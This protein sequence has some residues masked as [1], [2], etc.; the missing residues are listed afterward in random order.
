M[1]RNDSCILHV[2]GSAGLRAA[3]RTI[4]NL[5]HSDKEHGHVL[6]FEFN[7]QDHR[8]NSVEAMLSTFVAQIVSRY[9]D[10]VGPSVDGFFKSRLA[11]K[12]W[13]PID[14]YTVWVN[15]NM[16]AIS[17]L[18]T[19][20]V[21]SGLDQCKD[22]TSW[23]LPWLAQ[24]FT[25][26][27]GR[28][29]L[30]ITSA[31]VTNIQQKLK[32]VPTINLD[33]FTTSTGD[34][35]NWLGLDKASF[36]AKALQ[37]LSPT[38]EQQAMLDRI[39]S[40][41]W[42]D[43]DLYRMIL[44]WLANVDGF[45]ESPIDLDAKLQALTEL[46][47]LTPQTIAST[48]MEFVPIEARKIGRRAI[49][50]LL[51]SFQPLTKKELASVLALAPSNE[52]H[53][54]VEDQLT[55]IFPYLAGFFVITEDCV[56]FAHPNI[57]QVVLDTTPEAQ[58]L[59]YTFQGQDEVHAE[60]AQ[61]C[62]SYLRRID[63][64]KEMATS[65]DRRNEKFPFLDNN[66]D[67][68][69]Y[70]ACHWAKHYKLA[71]PTSSLWDQCLQFVNTNAGATFQCWAKFH[72]LLSNPATRPEVLLT[73][74]LAIASAL[75]LN[76]LVS[77][78]FQVHEAD[79]PLASIEA[80]RN[81]HADILNNHLSRMEP[82]NLAMSDIIRASLSSGN[83]DSLK[84]TVNYVLKQKL[85]LSWPSYLLHLVCMF[86]LN[87][88]AEKLLQS[89]V[90]VNELVFEKHSALHFASYAG[91]AQVVETLI[92]GGARVNAADA[93]YTPLHTACLWGHV[94]VAQALMRSGADLKLFT[95]DNYT[96]L[97]RSC[98]FG[99]YG[100]I[101]ILCKAE[102]LAITGSG[103]NDNQPILKC[104]SK[105]FLES[106]RTLLK[107]GADV[108]SHGPYRKTPLYCAVEGGHYNV[109][110][111]LLEKGANADQIPK[112]GG[113][114]VVSAAGSDHVEIVDLLLN[115]GRSDRS[116]LDKDRYIS[117]AATSLYGAVKR[118][119]LAMVDC[120]LRWGADI[121]MKMDD[122]KT[123]VYVAAENKNVDVLQRLVDAGADVDLVTTENFAALQIAH[124]SAE[125][126]RILLSAKKKPDINR[127]SPRGSILYRASKQNCV[128]VVEIL[129]QH[130]P[131]LETP[132]PYSDFYASRSPLLA[133]VYQ[134]HPEIVQMLLQA[135]ANINQ[136]TS[137]GDRPLHYAIWTKLQASNEECL[138]IL[139]E[140]HPDIDALD[141][142]LD[143]PLHCVTDET[144]VLSIRR[145]INAGADP[146]ISNRRGYT[147]V[148]MAII[149][150]NFP[151]VNYLVSKRRVKMDLP[152][153]EEGG[154]LHLACKIASLDCVKLLVEHHADV[155]LVNSGMAGTPLQSA[156]QRDPGEEQTQIIEYLINDPISKVD[157]NKDG[158]L[159]G[160][161]LNVASLMS[162]P[163]I[164][165]M[166]IDNHAEIDVEDYMSRNP[167][168]LAS[169][170]TLDHIDFFLD[171]PQLFS[172]QD[173]LGRTAIHFAVGSGRADLVK[174]VLT[175]C[176]RA[177]NTKDYDSWT[178]LMWAA[179]GCKNR[180]NYKDTKAD[181]QEEII[182][183]LLAQDADIWATAR[184]SGKDWSP[185][186]LAR[187]HGASD[188]II[189]LL[190]AKP[191]SISECPN[192]CN[193][194]SQ[195]CPVHEDATTT[196]SDGSPPFGD[197][198]LMS[199]WD[200]RLH[201]SKKA[202][203]REKK[204]CMACTFV[205]IENDSRRSSSNSASGIV[206]SLLPMFEML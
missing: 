166:L 174:K 42:P 58:D 17:S 79:L 156:C 170:R 158:G 149:K 184:N 49:A 44:G 55:P 92:K 177:P 123:P 141:V 112:Y 102:P 116:D 140:Y 15:P 147:P 126:V 60:I 14:L 76:D 70:V 28:L 96:P 143:T 168:H 130:N 183:F 133:A 175:L 24:T 81:G 178:P 111:L 34:N 98:V 75:G 114:V 80:A 136:S 13:N 162:T 66:Y 25:K 21:I 62:L 200:E 120:L 155:D 119:S 39:L 161:A 6:F 36:Q 134:G 198:K 10:T 181:Q 154:P 129:L 30:V 77:Y 118:G 85:S 190:S 73:S 100:V 56:Q 185:L 137:N 93:G 11:N 72:Y 9:W 124:D 3:S 146:E 64:Q 31:K 197:P 107:A 67:L 71:K 41:S 59:W 40:E 131:D 110:K 186:K 32:E 179:R 176:G 188:S 65:W 27:E 26:S 191:C 142:Q 8:F 89:G 68:L 193:P 122:G 45:I 83:P 206:R 201:T 20:Y 91:Y 22:S 153:G 74:P 187:Y 204:F 63:I 148:S 202:K 4:Y 29:K 167:A 43:D 33:D 125:I 105:G 117:Y 152:E 128:K 109:C 180:G 48:I 97:M 5:L 90:E 95:E 50:W 160:Y 54:L 103:D 38:T 113:H 144:P 127:S 194:L 94:E 135:G 57:Q 51:S 165:K 108:E 47:S 69:S 145:L 86:G 171:Y 159:F 78:L 99:K 52:T 205:S 199:L 195:S 138:K 35:L 121:N 172:A 192:A 182:R 88:I 164:I 203:R 1:K 12:V 19:T 132:G 157:V 53:I 115:H 2:Y 106:V 18:P 196:A 150:G 151:I 84:V 37:Q 163:E 104:A 16:H 87:D 189:Q 139:L 23:I 61:S 7:S 169:L 46:S 101:E 82:G 173:R